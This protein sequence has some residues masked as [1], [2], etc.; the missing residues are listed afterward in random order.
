MSKFRAL[1]GRIAASSWAAAIVGV[2]VAAPTASYGEIGRCHDIADSSGRL[3]CYDL[4]SGYAAE[5]SADASALG[6]WVVETEVSKIDDS[7]NVFLTLDS[8]T[9]TNCRYDSAPHQIG[10]ACRENQTNVWFFF[11]GCYMSGI[12]GRGA[13]T[14]RLDKDPAATKRFIESSD[15]TALG[16]WSGS[17][18]IP[19]IK[20]LLGHEKLFVQ[21]VPVS[22]SGVTAEYDITG[23]DEA[24]KPLREACN[25]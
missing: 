1:W 21:A 7:T 18:A 16:L 25:W 3:E 19:F 9:F 15:N 2:S 8:G 20:G 23:L 22:E 14:Y 24:I 17:S 5:P 4:E 11:G 13:V 12:Q 10:I 6:Q